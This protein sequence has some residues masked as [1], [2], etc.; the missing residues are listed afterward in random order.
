MGSSK[1]E[2]LLPPRQRLLSAR[3]SMW[4]ESY[5]ICKV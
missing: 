3:V 1:Y 5:K 2:V 4:T